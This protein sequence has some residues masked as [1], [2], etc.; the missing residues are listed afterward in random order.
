M[1]TMHWSIV[2]ELLFP[3]KTESRFLDAAKNGFAGGTEKSMVCRCDLH[4]I[5][6][7]ADVRRA[8]RFKR[9]RSHVS[10]GRAARL[11]QMAFKAAL[12]VALGRMAFDVLSK[13][14]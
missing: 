4:S 8:F 6:K 14:G 13:A 11:A 2:E 3:G 10:D 5:K 7:P 12:N 1:P 9:Q